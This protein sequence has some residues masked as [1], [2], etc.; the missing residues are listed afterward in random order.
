MNRLTQKKHKL[1]LSC[2]E[3]KLYE[4]EACKCKYILLIKC[5]IKIYMNSLKNLPIIEYN[6]HAISYCDINTFL[7][8]D[9][10][11]ND[12]NNKVRENIIGAII[13][14]KIPDKY[15]CYSGRWK[16]MKSIIFNYIYSLINENQNNGTI[17]KIICEHKGGRNYNYDF[18]IDI[19]DK[20]NFNIELKFNATKISE[21][22][23]FVSPMKP[24]QYLSSSYE[25]FHFD[26]FIPSIAKCGGFVIPSKNEYLNEIHSTSP[27]CISQYQE[28]YYSGC[29][30]SSKF[31]GLIEDINFYKETKKLSEISISDFIKNNELN[32]QKLSEYLME[33]QKNKYYMMYKD[34]VFYKE[35]V[36]MDEY[37]LISYEKQKNMFIATSKTGKKIKILL[38]WKNG[39]GIA[40][41][42]FQIS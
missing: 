15:Y 42:A 5:N 16:N 12:K 34:N 14:D 35:T 11:T 6:K 13:N 38:R 10:K 25:E 7:I 36:N 30:S 41:P 27:K 20:Y 9:K 19:N 40:F 22:P 23:Q 31:T 3:A 26:N 37:E 24:S 32:L 29:K 17:D 28:K 18:T 33:T 1:I 8:S 2:C 4:N 39:N 21:A